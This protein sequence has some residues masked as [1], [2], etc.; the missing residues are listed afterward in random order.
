MDFQCTQSSKNVA[1][2][3]LCYTLWLRMTSHGTLTS[4]VRFVLT[5]IWTKYPFS[6]E[7]PKSPYPVLVF[8]HGESFSWGSGNL[9]DGRVLATYANSVVV[10]FNYR[11]G[12]FGEFRKEESSSLDC[13]RCLFLAK[14]RNSNELKYPNKITFGAQLLNSLCNELLSGS[15]ASFSAYVT[16]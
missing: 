12:I 6:E 10:T 1:K 15:V 14:I 2:G 8:V 16:R 11:L 4:S 9:Y 13:C 5:L 3:F 7:P